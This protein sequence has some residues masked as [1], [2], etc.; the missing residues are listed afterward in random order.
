MD[1]NELSVEELLAQLKDLSVSEVSWWPPAPGWWILAFLL[2]VTCFWVSQYFHRQ[3]RRM[4]WVVAAESE[5]AQLERQFAS[6]AID[7]QT[8][9]SQLSVLMRRSAIAAMGRQSVARATDEQWIVLIAKIGNGQ[10]LGRHAA[11]TIAQAPFQAQPLP[12]EQVEHLL[13][14]SKKWLHGARNNKGMSNV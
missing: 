7:A 12:R 14:A 10:G 8:A 11:E 9:V 1:Q 13:S 4:R 2:V 6:Q 5:L 3:K